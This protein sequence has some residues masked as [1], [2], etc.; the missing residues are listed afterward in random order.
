MTLPNF[1]I[2]GAQKSGTTALYYYLEQQP[3]VYMSPIKEPHF[4]CFEGQNAL[5]PNS[6]A[7]IKTY[8]DL[9]KGAS[10]ERALGEAFP[11]Y[12][13][14]PKAVERIKTIYPRPS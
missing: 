3:Q 13:L 5:H 6:V 1:L 8:R 14:V 10:G 11:G 2:V 12:L 4:F 7:D 9:F